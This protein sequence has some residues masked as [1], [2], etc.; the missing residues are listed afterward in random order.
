MNNLS[1]FI[2]GAAAGAVAAT[3]ILGFAAVML[4]DGDD[5]LLGLAK[6]GDQGAGSGGVGPSDAAPSVFDKDLGDDG[7]AAR[8]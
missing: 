1:T 4:S 2:L 8:A 5:D 3:A 7:G 6:T